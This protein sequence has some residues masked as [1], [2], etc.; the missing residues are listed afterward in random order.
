MKEA[1]HRKVK[2]EELEY[3]CS[4]GKVGNCNAKILFC[5]RNVV[6]S[7]DVSTYGEWRTYWTLKWFSRVLVWILQKGVYLR[8]GLS[9]KWLIWKC[10]MGVGH[11]GRHT[12]ETYNKEWAATSWWDV[13]KSD[14][15]GVKT[16]YSLLR[17]THYI[18]FT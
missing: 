6:A 10:C 1:F 2:E 13:Q 17:A 9:W 12:S 3:G 15:A 16:S 7:D 4:W 18:L 14:G 5:T 11:Q 8:L